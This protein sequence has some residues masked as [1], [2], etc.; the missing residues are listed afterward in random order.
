MAEGKF[1]GNV[2]KIPEALLRFARL[3][4]AQA[5][6]GKDGKPKMRLDK[7]TGQLIIDQRF[8]VTAVLDPTRK[9]HADVIAV[10]K[11]EATRA[12]NHRYTSQDKWPQRNKE[13]GLGG[14]IY[15][16]GLGNN[17]Q[18]VYEGFKNMWY[19]KLSDTVRPLTWNRRHE[20]V[21][22]GEPQFP[23]DGSI[24]N[25]SATLWSYDNESRGVNANLREVQ[26]VKD[27]KPFTG[28]NRGGDDFAALGDD[29]SPAASGGGAVKDPFDE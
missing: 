6:T 8:S 4:K 15:C 13:T 14:L 24:S 5:R 7:T 3:D 19:I 28:G 22:A 21:I 23:Y 26:F 16:F 10:V 11:E 1:V 20:P 9:I 29:D 12:L 2:I 27:G 17:M 18:K 25:V